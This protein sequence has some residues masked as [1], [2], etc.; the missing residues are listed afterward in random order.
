MK[1]AEEQCNLKMAPWKPYVEPRQWNEAYTLCYTQRMNL[2]VIGIFSRTA[3]SL[4][5][6]LK[7]LEWLAQKLC[8]APPLLFRYGENQFLVMLGAA[9]WL[10]LNEDFQ[11]LLLMQTIAALLT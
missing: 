3:M 9:I 2:N 7:G 11:L 8:N 10:S 1:Q 4:G 5:G 6:G